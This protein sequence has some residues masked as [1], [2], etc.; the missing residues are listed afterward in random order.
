[1]AYGSIRLTN[2]SK[3]MIVKRDKPK[4]EISQSMMNRLKE[5]S[6][7]HKNGMKS[8]H[9]RNMKQFIMDGKS[10]NEAHKMAI[11]LDN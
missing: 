1:M 2:G 5:H 6:K 11:K 3:S 4:K 9:M 7:L 8:R 10:F